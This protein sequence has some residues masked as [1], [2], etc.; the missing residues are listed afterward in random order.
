MTSRRFFGMSLVLLLSWISTASGQ[1]DDEFEQWQRAERESFQRFIEERDREFLDFLEREWREMQVFQGIARDTIPKPRQIPVA[2]VPPPSA[3]Q[4]P[5]SRI[6]QPLP[7]LSPPPPPLPPPALVDNRPAPAEKEGRRTFSFTFFNAPLS[8]DCDETLIAPGGARIDKEAIAAFWERMSR[9]EYQDCLAQ[10]EYYRKQMKLN[11]WGYCLLLDEIGEALYPGNPNQKVLF[12]WFMLS[13]SGYETRI[14]YD[15]RQV[16]L[17]LSTKNTLYSQ[18]YFTLDGKPF[19]VVSTGKTDESVG[20]LYTYDGTYPGAEKVVDFALGYPP[21][22]GS[23]DI[24][25]VLTFNYRGTEYRLPV[26]LNTEAISFLDYYPQTNFEVYFDAAL[27]PEAT[28]SL[29]TALKPLIAGRSEIE[30][31]GLL[32][33]FVQTAFA[34]QTDDE[35]FHREKPL[36]PDETLFYPFSDC[37]DRSILFAYLVR[38]LL[39]LS[40]IGLDYPGHIATAV[41]FSDGLEIG[42]CV[43]YNQE[44]YAICDPTYINA[45][46]GMAMPIFKEVTP[47]IIPIRGRTGSP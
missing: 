30:A 11:D 21:R 17:L 24:D 27:S 19:Y 7:L 20:S 5:E 1:R 4:L 32:L 47:E 8:I 43:V 16:Y 3:V 46:P 2:E 39:G 9:A 26:K 38:E 25:K 33:H 37:E 44:K 41:R 13:K 14:G 23:T 28:S 35:Q 18:P 31:V 15:D 40:V 10:A 12:K 36:F 22:I 45:D 34:Y 29:L 6:V 42:D